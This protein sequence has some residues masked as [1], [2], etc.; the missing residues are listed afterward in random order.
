[1]VAESYKKKEQTLR[2]QKHREPEVVIH[3]RKLGLF[4]AGATL[5]ASVTALGG[6][7]DVPQHHVKVLKNYGGNVS[8]LDGPTWQYTGVTVTGTDSWDGRIWIDLPLDRSSEAK[9]VY[10]TADGAL[11]VDMN[12]A[13]SRG[14]SAEERKKWFINTTDALGIVKK[15]VEGIARSVVHNYSN[16]EILNAELALKDVKLP[17]YTQIQAEL[18]K[19]QFNDEYGIDKKSYAVWP[20]NV[21]PQQGA[22][23]ADLDRQR[24]NLLNAA[25]LEGQLSLEKAATRRAQVDR[26]YA[27]FIRT[28]TP[29][30]QTYLRTLDMSNAIKQHE[31]PESTEKIEFMLGGGQR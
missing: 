29:A 8:F 10:Q 15:D 5:T 18:G 4:L 22:V 26:K 1:V 31:R 30:Q 24:N 20:G 3:M 16:A 28:L 7:S 2:R 9:E 21:S 6:C 13:F 11:L 23:Q 14:K 19:A 17:V 25:K 27:D 12:F